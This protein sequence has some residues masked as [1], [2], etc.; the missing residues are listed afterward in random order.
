MQKLKMESAFSNGW[1]IFKDNFITLVIAFFVVS[2]F[3]LTIILAPVML[4]GFTYMLL[5][6]SKGEAI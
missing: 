3:S 6:A 1:Q 5:R 4:A 2:L